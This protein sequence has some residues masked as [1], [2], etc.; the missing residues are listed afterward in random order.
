MTEGNVTTSGMV[1]TLNKEAK[2][3][4]IIP[5]AKVIPLGTPAKSAKKPKVT[6]EKA[7]KQPLTKQE[8]VERKAKAPKKVKVAKAKP[9]KAKKAPKEKAKGGPSLQIKD[10]AKVG[11]A[12]KKF[13]FK[14]KRQKGECDVLGCKVKGLG[15]KRR[16]P[17]HKK[18]IRKAQL[19][20]NNVVWRKR[21]KDG[22]AGHHAVYT[23]SD[24]GKTRATKFAVK[25]ADKALAAVKAGHSVV[26]VDGF[27]KALAQAEK[28]KVTKKAKKVKGKK[29]A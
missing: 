3:E 8:K 27:K 4:K 28:A 11:P 1:V 16:C 21:V 24:E 9:A 7:L 22:V 14:V 6:L 2:V 5:G 17:K 20:A 25:A 19:K 15:S 10:R 12:M 23:D 29:A 18:L 26:D 13:K